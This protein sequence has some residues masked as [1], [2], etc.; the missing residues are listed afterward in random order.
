MR[1]PRRHATWGAVVGVVAGVPAL[2]LLACSSGSPAPPSATP[3]GPGTV[4]PPAE[5]APAPTATVPRAFAPPV[6]SANPTPR[7]GATAQPRAG[8][9]AA[10]PPGVVSRVEGPATVLSVVG[11]TVIDVLVSGDVYRVRLA[12]VALPDVWGVVGCYGEESRLVVETLAPPGSAL[13]LEAAPEQDDDLPGVYA[14]SD[15]GLV[16]ERL[17]EAGYAL[18]RESGARGRHGTALIDAERAAARSILGLW[19]AAVGIDSY[20]NGVECESLS[21]YFSAAHVGT[22][23]LIG[24]G[25]PYGHYR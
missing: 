18:V 14:W 8:G 21:G 16:N 12:G 10:A 13:T 25:V 6:L 15:E 9:A 23:A 22:S 4:L 3:G 1:R 7:P 24:E 5:T 20:R 17:V 19:G 2:L 11:V